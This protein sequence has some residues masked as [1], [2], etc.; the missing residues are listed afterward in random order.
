MQNCTNQLLYELIARPHEQRPGS[1]CR[2]ANQSI[3]V[4]LCVCVCDFMHV[5]VSKCVSMH[6]SVS[7]GQNV[8]VQAQHVDVCT[9]TAV[10][11]WR[12]NT[13]DVNIVV[14]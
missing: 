2:L 11:S 14:P 3:D 7:V 12:G 8:C 4:C 1:G 5:Q 13:N 6:V 10:S 9:R